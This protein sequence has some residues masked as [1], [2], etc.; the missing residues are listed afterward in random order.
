MPYVLYQD[1]QLRVPCVS[2]G[3]SFSKSRNLLLVVWRLPGPDPMAPL[4]PVVLCLKAASEV[5]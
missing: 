5:P 2:V 3:F 4:V 1:T